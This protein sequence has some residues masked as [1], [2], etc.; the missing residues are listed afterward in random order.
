MTADPDRNVVLRG[1]RELVERAGPLLAAAAEDFACAAA[2]LRTWALPGAREEIVAERHRRAPALRARKLYSPLA[3]ADEE[4]ERHLVELAARG[5]QVR[6]CPAGLPQETILVDGRAAVLAGP[7]ERGV[8]SF[9]VVRSP[10]VVRGI[11]A[12]YQAAWESAIDLA[13][14]RRARP[15]MPDEEG[16]RILGMLAAGL[17]DEAA[18]RRLG[19]SLRTY[20]R[21]V[22]GLMKL[23]DARSRFQAG[24]RAQ[25]LG[26]VPAQA[27]ASHRSGPK[28]S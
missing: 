16:R 10:D 22:T 5:A 3:V 18:A 7:I 11:R 9:T 8:R 1:E 17:T 21:R 14:Y 6:I 23:L 24:L 28:T 25:Q 20:R 13:A 4:S 19:M 2:D 15:P 26:L 27:S 12:L